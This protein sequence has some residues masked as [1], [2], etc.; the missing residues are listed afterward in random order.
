MKRREFI[1]KLVKEDFSRLFNEGRT[2]LINIGCG[3]DQ[4]V[5][6]ITAV[7]DEVVGYKKDVRWD[8][9]KPDGTPQKLLNISQKKRSGPETDY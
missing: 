8:Q 7:V 9:D 1:R 5:K 2:P 6:E 4:T 3:K